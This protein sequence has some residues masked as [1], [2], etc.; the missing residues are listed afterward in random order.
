MSDAPTSD[1]AP[2]L[3][4]ISWEDKRWSW[5][6][7]HAALHAGTALEYFSHTQFYDR[8]CLNAHLHMQG[9]TL[10]QRDV[11]EKLRRLPGIVYQFD[12][13]RS[14]GLILSDSSAPRRSA[15]AAATARAA[16]AV[17]RR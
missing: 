14:E 8:T 17:F 11:D 16:P 10:S 3:T 13:S 6:A 5:Q 4:S 7:P 15:A 2:T 9:R 1:D 12:G